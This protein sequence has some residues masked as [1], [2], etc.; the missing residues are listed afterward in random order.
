M[1]KPKRHDT[2]YGQ[3]TD[4]PLVCGMALAML[5]LVTMLWWMSQR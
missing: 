2:D 3:G 1:S 4:W 5:A